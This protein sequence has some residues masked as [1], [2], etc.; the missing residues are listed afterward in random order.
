MALGEELADRRSR[1]P[2]G[3]VSSPTDRWKNDEDDD[4]TGGETRGEAKADGDV[5]GDAEPGVETPVL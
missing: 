5:P 3:E 1:E 4:G 2:R